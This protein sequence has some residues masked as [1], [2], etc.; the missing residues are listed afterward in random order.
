[1]FIASVTDLVKLL[2]EC[3]LLEPT[4]LAELP[5]LQSRFAAAEA[6][7][8]ELVKRGWLTAYQVNELFLGRGGGL[9][10][11]SYVLLERLGQGGMGAVFKARNWKLHKTVA[12]KL[13]RKERLAHPDAVKRFQ[14]EIQAVARLNHPNI[15]HA[16]DADEVNG[17]SFLV[18]EFI[19]GGID[20]DALAKK[21]GPLPVATSCAYIHQAA[22]G[23]QHA[24]EHGLVHRDIK[25]HNLLMVSG[26][27]GASGTGPTTHHS[28]DTTHQIK[29][30][31]MGLARWSSGDG[32]ESGLTLT[33]ESAVMGTPDYIAPEQARASH[34]VDIRADLY[35]LG[36]TWYFLLAGRVLFPGGTLTEKLLRHQM[37]EPRPIA[38]LRPDV[39]PELAAV[40]HQLLAKRAEDRCQTPGELAA[41]LERLRRE[42]P[43]STEP[44]RGETLDSFGTLDEKFLP[45]AA[46]APPGAVPPRHWLHG[47]RRLVAAAAVLLVLAVAGVYGPAL[48]RVRDDNQRQL[49][50]RNEVP[51]PAAPNPPSNPF[52]LQAGQSVNVLRLLEADPIIADKWR[53][54]AGEL[55]SEP[56]H[57][58]RL[59]LPVQ[60][61]GSYEFRAS[62]TRSKEGKGAIHFFLPAAKT[63][64]L[65]VFA[66]DAKGTSG[67]AY[68]DGQGV[69]KNE[70]RVALGRWQ[71]KE[72]RCELSVRVV[73]KE[74]QADI[75]VDLDW[76]DGKRTIPWS[77]PQTALS[78]PPNPRPNV[79][80]LGS[81]D[82][83]IRYHRLELRVLDGTANLLLPPL[84][85]AVTSP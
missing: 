84:A 19:E 80:V 76:K 43:M 31:D 74:D 42:V 48:Y 30:L 77:G 55:V 73:L 34:N 7:A 12:V 27:G 38:R 75:K 16:Y 49:V 29:I 3:R 50:I 6:V 33:T 56:D 18:T 52:T 5:A 66:L 53:I 62:F 14:R 78:S 37:D 23:L 36:A 57:Q 61:K 28:P 67:I 20:L 71:K 24:H 41:L 44:P 22:L 39:P 45:P 58:P 68:I 32:P 21:Q 10:L 85:G 60:P 40:I 17:T 81:F 65:L 25:P 9:L 64:C 63:S 83:N 70:T 2:G 47:R 59:P 4:Q 82:G 72:L 13:I 54:E 51:M 46:A 26:G 15:L 79:V 1:M 69:Q 35:S 8:K 11:G